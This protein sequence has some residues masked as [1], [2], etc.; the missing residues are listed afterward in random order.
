[1]IF[2][3][4]LSGSHNAI[5][6]NQTKRT[7]IMFYSVKCW[8]GANSVLPYGSKFTQDG[9]DFDVEKTYFS[10]ILGI[11]CK[12]KTLL[13]HFILHT[14]TYRMLK[15]AYPIPGLEPGTCSFR[16]FLP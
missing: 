8:E 11:E 2:S 5:V 3:L 14:W 4:G 6:F 10:F 12:K 16:T 7:I 9:A 15:N 1:M 13:I